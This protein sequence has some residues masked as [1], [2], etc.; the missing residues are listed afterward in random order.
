ME[1]MNYYISQNKNYD[2]RQLYSSVEIE[3][4]EYLFYNYVIS[5]IDKIASATL[6]NQKKKLKYN[7]SIVL[8]FYFIVIFEVLI[9]IFY[10]LFL[11]QKRIIY[12]L[13]VARCIF[14]II[15]INIIYSTQELSSYI[16]NDFN[17]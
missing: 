14:R 2:T 16:E 12:L 8:S 7:K 5:F 10:I 3:E 1:L 13:S 4:C 17:N 11:F 6:N 15:P 9:Y